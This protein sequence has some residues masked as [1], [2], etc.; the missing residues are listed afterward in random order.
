M[1][2]QYVSMTKS[3]DMCSLNFDLLVASSAVVIH[4]SEV[5]QPASV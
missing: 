4:P 3:I 1:M 2:L 5:Y